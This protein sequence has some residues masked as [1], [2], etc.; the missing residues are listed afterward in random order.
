M[1]LD[2]WFPLA[3]YY[4]DLPEAAQH[5]QAHSRQHAGHRGQQLQLCALGDGTAQRQHDL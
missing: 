5:T 1:P 3:L 4:A 2:T